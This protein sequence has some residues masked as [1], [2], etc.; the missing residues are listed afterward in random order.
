MGC[1]VNGPGEA[2]DADV[3]IACGKGKGAIFRK[4]KVVSTVA[5][6]DFLD[7]LMAEIKGL[8]INLKDK[9]MRFSNLFGKTLKEI[10]SEADT[11]SHQLLLRT[12]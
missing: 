4:G 6:K 2:K 9:D 7:A 10:P 11:I 5:E 12:G 1:V 3:G 8:L